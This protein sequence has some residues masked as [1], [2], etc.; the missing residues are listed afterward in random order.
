MMA[1]ALDILNSWLSEFA[2][3]VLP[4]FPSSSK[5]IHFPFRKHFYQLCRHRR[6]VIESSV[7]VQ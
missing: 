6:I 7:S 5:P 2:A 3:P 4:F 1:A